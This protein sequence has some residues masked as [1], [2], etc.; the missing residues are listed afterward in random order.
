MGSISSL[1]KMVSGLQAAQKG[2]QVTGQNIANINTKGY[3]RQ[4]LLQ[5]ETGYITIGS[6]GGQLMQVGLGVSGTEIRQIRDE[7][8][9]KRLRTENSVLNYY[10]KLTAAS[11]E[12]G[13]LFDEPYGDTL[14]DMLN[15]F[16][17]QTQK[18]SITTD[19]VEERLSFIATSKAL[20]T[21]INDLST[22]L[23]QY[24]AQ[25]NTQVENAIKDIN[26]I[27]SDIRDYNE[28]IAIHEVNGDNANDY[29]DQ[30]NVLLDN[31]SAYGD[32]DYY[33][34][35]DS[36]IVVKFEGHVVVNKMFINTLEMEQ[37]VTGSPFNKPVWS[38]TKQDVY[39]LSDA[40]SSANDND[41][42][43]LKALLLLRGENYV[44]SETTW[45]DVA[46]NDN[47]SVDKPGNAYVI[48]KYEMMLNT[49]ANKL[50]D[51]V[52]SNFD[53]TGIGTH[54]G[55]KGVQVFVPIHM[56]KDMKIPDE[57]STEEEIAA[58]K[59]L[60]V[61]GNIQVNPELLE[62]GGYNKLGTVGGAAEDTGDNSKVTAFLA[63][64]DSTIDWFDDNG[65]TSPLSKSVNITN[66]YSEFVTDMGTDGSL[67]AA[68][69]NE[70]NIS[71]LNVENERQSMGG[72]SQDEEFS[73]MLQYQYAYNASAR[74]IT[75][76]DGMIDT[77][78][79]K[80]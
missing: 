19:G 39:N 49:F 35:A 44:T 61:P 41:T 38:D 40:V 53:G 8:A 11:E 52:N 75:I 56:P 15:D 64:W 20:I 76:M 60:L 36:R 55:K 78:I 70:K 72:V 1:S 48:P 62:S 50:V 65:K 30:R 3:T 51:M 42:G 71:V 12:I 45:D 47:Y 18:L 66:F 32:I 26:Q 22:G 24:Q 4:Q 59:A 37:V 21:K 54:E 43:A 80:L 7:L 9:D 77:I 6:N 68:K 34:E 46:L 10:Q 14:S 33:E 17:T 31:L 69:A 16:W 5:H 79:N 58:Y 29:R 13:A 74:V 25:V 28:L 63:Q 57:N 67:Y 27:I 73:Y 23:S 2:L